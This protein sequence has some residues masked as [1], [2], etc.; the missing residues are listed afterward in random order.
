MSTVYFKRRCLDLVPAVTC[1]PED[2]HVIFC[3]TNW[4]RTGSRV[5]PLRRNQLEPGRL[6]ST[7]YSAIGPF[8][9]AAF[10]GVTCIAKCNDP[11]C[12][13]PEAND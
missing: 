8:P 3:S 6:E 11:L 12:D 2:L 4:I 9:F 7:S 5:K 1:V 13:A 10:G